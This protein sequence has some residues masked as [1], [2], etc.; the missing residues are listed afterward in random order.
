MN[1]RRFS[2]AEYLNSDRNGRRKLREEESEEESVEEDLELTDLENPEE[3]AREPMPGKPR[4]SRSCCGT[5]CRRLYTA[6]R[7][8]LA[9]V[10]AGIIIRAAILT[11]EYGFLFE[12][13]FSRFVAL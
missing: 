6:F 12:K 13:L 2:A 7:V 10:F 11:G 5:L 8:I 4:K 3:M 9:K 1:V